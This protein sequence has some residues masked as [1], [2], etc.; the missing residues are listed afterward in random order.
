MHI[1]VT[2]YRIQNTE[3]HVHKITKVPVFFNGVEYNDFEAGKSIS[4]ATGG[5]GPE[6]RD[7]FGPWNGNELVA[8]DV[9]APLI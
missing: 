9:Q 6:N 8:A 4:R 1:K 5:V 2:K 7:F 3:T